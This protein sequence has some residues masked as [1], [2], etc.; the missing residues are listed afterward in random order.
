M[1]NNSLTQQ[2]HDYEL[3]INNELTIENNYINHPKINSFFN[4]LTIDLNELTA[5]FPLDEFDAFERDG[6]SR[7][8][9]IYRYTLAVF[10]KWIKEGKNNK[11]TLAGFDRK[12]LVYTVYDCLHEACWRYRNK[13]QRKLRGEQQYLSNSFFFLHHEDLEINPPEN[14][15][16]YRYIDSNTG[17]YFDLDEDEWVYISIPFFGNGELSDKTEGILNQADLLNI[18]VVIDCSLLPLAK[19]FN[20]NLNR[21]C[22]KEVI[23]PICD[24]IGIQKSRLCIRFSKYLDKDNRGADGS[25][26][27]PPI[28]LLNNTINGFV[29]PIDL[30]VATKV[31]NTFSIDYMHNACKKHQLTICQELELIPTSCVN[32]CMI[33]D[34]SLWWADKKM[35]ELY[36]EH[37]DASNDLYPRVDIS[38][39]INQKLKKEYHE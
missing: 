35:K 18:P 37:K 19:G 39:A 6:Y 25:R 27:V 34:D 29:P 36:A 15:P 2:W 26:G 28:Q 38:H 24:N 5:G 9:E 1:G 7:D 4:N 3:T 31:L 12:D 13:R 17:K 22:I 10:T 32:I 33:P 11:I 23:F 21:P 16:F 20:F 14:K 30:L 8:E